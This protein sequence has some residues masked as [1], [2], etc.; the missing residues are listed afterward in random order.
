MISLYFSFLFIFFLFPLYGEVYRIDQ[1]G[2]STISPTTLP[3]NKALDTLVLTPNVYEFD[4]KKWDCTK[5]GLYI[6]FNVPR[7]SCQ[8]I[9]YNKDVRTL[10]HSLTWLHAHGYMDDTASFSI[11]QSTAKSRRLH[12]SC[13]S[14]VNFTNN[15]LKDLSVSSRFVLFLTLNEWNNYSNGHSVLEVFDK[16]KWIVYDIDLRNYFTDNGEVLNAYELVAAVSSSLFEIHHFSDSPNFAFGDL[17]LNGFD[18]SLW[19]ESTLLFKEQLPNFYQRV[20]QVVLIRE[21]GQFF[22][23]CESVDQRKRIESYDKSFTYMPID[24][25]MNHFYP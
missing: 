20:C 25:F 18:Y 23:T 14:F 21:N 15:L 24:H 4:N 10:I 19:C 9:I 8:R 6:F 7:I 13:G 1:I 12:M 16:G 2:I 3:D 11:A 17:V 22:F 5:E